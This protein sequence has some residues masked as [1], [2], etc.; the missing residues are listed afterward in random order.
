MELTQEYTLCFSFS[1]RKSRNEIAWYLVW[2]SVVAAAG[3][4]LVLYVVGCSQFSGGLHGLAVK[5]PFTCTRL[6]FNL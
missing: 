1:F 3:L 2:W 6:F 4:K 5:V